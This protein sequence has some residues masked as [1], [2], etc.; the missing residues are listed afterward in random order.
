M[1]LSGEDN[2][3]GPF[4]WLTPFVFNVALLPSRARCCEGRPAGV[5]GRRPD[6]DTSDTSN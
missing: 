3:V 4:L 5:G 6:M 1:T 2:F